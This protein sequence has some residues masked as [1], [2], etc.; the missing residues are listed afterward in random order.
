MAFKAP[1]LNLQQVWAQ[2]IKSQKVKQH[3]GILKID[4]LPFFSS[5]ASFCLQ[6]FVSVVS[7][8]QLW[9]YA[10]AAPADCELTE[11]WNVPP[12]LGCTEGSGKAWPILWLFTD[13]ALHVSHY[14]DNNVWVYPNY[15]KPKDILI[16]L[17]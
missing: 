10:A 4:I 7:L 3:K 1:R 16:F 14:E 6:L 17:T 13:V 2:F 12:F 15:C 5:S 8:Y 11:L 9:I